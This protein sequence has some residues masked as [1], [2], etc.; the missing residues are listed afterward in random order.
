LKNPFTAQEACHIAEISTENLPTLVCP[1]PLKPHLEFTEQLRLGFIE[2]GTE[3]T[4]FSGSSA[5]LTAANKILIDETVIKSL[6]IVDLNDD[7]LGPRSTSIREKI[8]RDDTTWKDMVTPSAAKY[9][10]SLNIQERLRSLERGNKKR[11]WA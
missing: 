2:L 8:E 5:T 10:D 9:I 11:P 3:I 7:G 1:F 4:V 6:Q